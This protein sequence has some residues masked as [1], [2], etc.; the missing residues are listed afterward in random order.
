V[1]VRPLL[2]EKRA[3]VW[4]EVFNADL[5]PQKVSF[6]VSVFGQNFPRIARR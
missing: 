5:E 6:T 1:F 4:I 2:D 3:E